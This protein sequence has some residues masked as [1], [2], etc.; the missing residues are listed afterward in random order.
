[1]RAGILIVSARAGCAGN[2][3]ATAFGGEAGV[4]A[5][6][7]TQIGAAHFETEIRPRFHAHL[8]HAARQCSRARDAETRAGRGL[9]R[10]R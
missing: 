2:G 7:A 6:V 5:Q 4:N 3:F 9:G 8:H 10:N 1:M